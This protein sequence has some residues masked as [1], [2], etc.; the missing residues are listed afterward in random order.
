MSGREAKRNDERLHYKF[1][2][3]YFEHLHED[4]YDEAVKLYE[5]TKRI[6]PNVKDLTKTAHFMTTVT[7]SI[8]V[9]RYYYTRQLKQHHTPQHMVE[10]GPR[11]VLQIP[12]QK[13]P[14]PLIHQP[15][16]SQPSPL[17]H[18]PSPSQPSPLIHQPSP[19]QPCMSSP[20][21]PAQLP[22]DDAVFQQLLKEIAQD[23]SLEQILNNF[24]CDDNDDDDMNSL[25]Q[26][27][28]FTLNDMSPLETDLLNIQ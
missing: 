12:L 25:V 8:P 10:R 7:P 16:P 11:M 15:S 28:V 21:P 6:N 17:I 14:S 27:D 26:N 18:Q 1:L 23:P 19:S 2:V 24:H 9:P 20:P 3:K 22:L 5:E 13:Q 4:L